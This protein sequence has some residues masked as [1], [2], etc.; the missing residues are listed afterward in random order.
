MTG[1]ETRECALRA[2]GTYS[3]VQSIGRYDDGG[4]DRHGSCAV[5][6]LLVSKACSIYLSVCLPVPLFSDE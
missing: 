2:D 4:R 6:V 3:G 5:Q 1:K